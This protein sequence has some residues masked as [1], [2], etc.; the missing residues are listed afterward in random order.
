MI[1]FLQ[2]FWWAN[3]RRLKLPKVKL[4]LFCTP[5]KL[6]KANMSRAIQISIQESYFNL[7]YLSKTTVHLKKLFF[8]LTQKIA[9]TWKMLFLL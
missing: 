2:E 6:I 1:S 5:C 4:K 9:M 7:N 3:L 8:Q